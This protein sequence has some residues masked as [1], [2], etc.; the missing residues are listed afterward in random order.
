MIFFKSNVF[1]NSLEFLNQ[2]YVT[3]VFC[4]KLNSNPPFFLCL[5]TSFI[6]TNYQPIQRKASYNKA[7]R[8]MHGYCIMQKGLYV[9]STIYKYF[10]WLEFKWHSDS[11]F[12]NDEFLGHYPI[13]ITWFWIRRDKY[14]ATEVWQKKKNFKIKSTTLLL[15]MLYCALFINTVCIE[16]ANQLWMIS[17]D[18]SHTATW[19]GVC[20]SST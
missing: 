9:S 16:M 20:Q 11:D 14:S 5:N 1:V 8:I 13:H 10:S 15:V 3:E 4:F 18:R 17:N 2:G 19:L 12:T 6:F 7:V